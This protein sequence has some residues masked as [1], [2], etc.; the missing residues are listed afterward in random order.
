[1]F[2]V[3]KRN[4][5]ILWFTWLW[6]SHSFKESHLTNN[7]MAMIYSVRSS[8][9]E[10][11]VC[12]SSWYQYRNCIFLYLPSSF[13]WVHRSV[14]KRQHLI[15]AKQIAAFVYPPLT[16]LDA[17][18][19]FNTKDWNN[20]AWTWTLSACIKTGARLPELQAAIRVQ[21]NRQFSNRLPIRHPVMSEWLHTSNMWSLTGVP[22]TVIRWVFRQDEN[23]TNPQTELPGKVLRPR[24]RR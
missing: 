13:Y 24:T 4:T 15:P 3:Y 20:A 14:Y 8:R 22:H 5:R 2:T 18:K 9:S 19:Y 6:M 10:S 12:E 1:M 16:I 17:G 23:E 21:L 7:I 11:L